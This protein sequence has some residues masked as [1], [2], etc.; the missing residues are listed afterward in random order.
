MKI[1]PRCVGVPLPRADCVDPADPLKFRRDYPVP[2][3]RS[4]HTGIRTAL[5]RRC[6]SQPPMYG[7]HTGREGERRERERAPSLT[8]IGTRTHTHTHAYTPACAH[9]YSVQ[10]KQMLIHMFTFKHFLRVAKRLTAICE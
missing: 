2:L 5:C 1:P 4:A 3:W 9:A 8:R 10:V 6:S 7:G